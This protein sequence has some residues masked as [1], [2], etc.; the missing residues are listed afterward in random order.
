MTAKKLTAS[1]VLFDTPRVQIEAVLKS[2]FDSACVE[3][4]YIIDNSPND[5]WRILE[6][7]SL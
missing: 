2:V 4:L 1:I 6:N 3:T 5:K 7:R